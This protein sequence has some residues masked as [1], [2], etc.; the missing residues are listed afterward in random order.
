MVRTALVAIS[1]LSASSAISQETVPPIWSSTTT[2][3]TYSVYYRDVE[4]G[5]SGWVT[6]WLRGDHT[7]DKTVP[8]RTS[9]W[10]IQ[11]SCH[12]SVTFLASSTYAAN[13]RQ[14]SSWDGTYTQ[15]IRP[16]TMY[17]SL[18]RQFCKK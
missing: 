10:R 7:N 13:R 4:F 12:G 8:Y 11:L 2:G 9:V 5:V 18:D 1:L 16:D 6:L 17:E 15:A 14:M 3:G